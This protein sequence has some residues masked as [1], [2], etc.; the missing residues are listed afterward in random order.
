MRRRV[1]G[2]D[3]VDEALLEFYEYI[4]PE[5]EQIW[6]KPGNVYRNLVIEREIVDKGH[7]TVVRHIQKLARAGLLEAADDDS[8][9]YALTD[10]GRSYLNDALSEEEREAIEDAI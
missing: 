5:G 7:A 6:I 2:M 3:Q 1:D 4:T 9:F 10:L 8:G